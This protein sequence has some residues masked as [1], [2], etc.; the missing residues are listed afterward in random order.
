[1]STKFIWSNKNIVTRI[2]Q[3]WVSSILKNKVTKAEIEEM[4]T[5]TKSDHNMVLVQLKTDYFFGHSKEVSL[6]K[7]QPMRHVWNLSIA[8]HENWENYRASLWR[9]LQ[10]Q[11]LKYFLS[12]NLEKIK[13][14]L[15]KE[16]KQVDKTWISIEKAIIRVAKSMPSNKL[17]RIP[18]KQLVPNKK[19]HIFKAYMNLDR[20]ISEIKKS[21]IKMEP[22]D[23]D[24][25]SSS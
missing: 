23:Q 25:Q 18:K 17:I 19:H 9:Q 6:G 7:K 2:D 11:I 5:V 15:Q 24:N 14:G 3:I 16:S 4:E 20:L 13:K 8:M 22:K 1:E 21:D 10:K 12:K